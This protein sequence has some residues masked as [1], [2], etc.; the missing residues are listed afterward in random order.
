MFKAREL[1]FIRT[2]TYK[3]LWGKNNNQKQ[4][5]VYVLK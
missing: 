1:I 5:F 3:H 2:N 4:R